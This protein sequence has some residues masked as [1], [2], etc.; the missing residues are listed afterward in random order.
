MS[1][2]GSRMVFFPRRFGSEERIARRMAMASGD[3]CPDP[4]VVLVRPR[5]LGRSGFKKGM[6]EHK[7]KSSENAS[8]HREHFECIPPNV[9]P[10]SPLHV[11]Y[12]H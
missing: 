12:T 7:C 1:S 9:I 8:T 5:E 6:G 4:E 10:I 2:S 3:L 11:V